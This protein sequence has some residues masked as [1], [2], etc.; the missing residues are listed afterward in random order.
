VST[1]DIGFFPSDTAVHHE[2]FT[3]VLT[4]LDSFQT[5]A[6]SSFPKIRVRDMVHSWPVDTLAAPT[7]AGT[8]DGVDWNGDVLTTPLRL[9]NGTQ[10]FSRHV[11][12][13]DR[14]RAAN[15]AGIRDMY[16][17]QIMKEF[18]VLA[19]NA[20]YVLFKSTAVVSGAAS[21]IVSGSE[22][23][24]INWSTGHFVT[25][26]SLYS[27]VHCTLA[28]PT[29][30]LMNASRSVTHI[31]GFTAATPREI[32]GMAAAGL[33]DDLLLANQSVDPARLRAMAECGGR[34]T[35][36][37]DSEATIVAAADA[38]IREVV[39]DV[40]V[41][42][43]RCGCR[44]D[45][46]ARIADVAR[47]R[48]MTVRGVMGYE[49][50]A[51]GIADRAER[52]A[53]TQEAM[54]RLAAAHDAVGGDVVSSGGTGTYDINE[55][56][57]EIQAG[58]YALMDTAY[59]ELDS[60]F[61]PALRIVAT[62]V[63]ANA[64]FAVAD[65]GL[66]ALGM[67]SLTGSLEPGKKADIVLIKNDA[68]PVMFPLLNPYG[69]VAFQAQ[70]GD[71]HTVVVNGRVVKYGHRLLGVDLAKARDVVGQTVE[72]LM[73]E[74]GQDAWTDGMHPEIPA[75]ETRDNP[76]TYTDWDAGSA[77]WKK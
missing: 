11:G 72:H 22:T 69:H 51:V 6:F 61:Q 10:I 4:I 9:F 73:S 21:S 45:D 23:T 60:P 26:S 39:V 7:T 48:G 57:T 76:Y 67:D 19:R 43:P 12:V 75:T 54:T 32:L 35:V 63:H 49:G 1:Y 66:K 42:M 14:E 24:S 58:S 18:K 31:T 3:D 38:G 46:A 34:I 77:Q 70:R 56:A 36:A 37:V 65:C 33:G 55:L 41:G 40:N 52:T 64:K 16:E 25:S 27:V 28:L 71:V 17:H 15:P 50:H 74:L 68:S 2:D 62:I 44:P 5:P 29:R 30:F 8:P 59:A 47:A 20:E 13:S 53:K